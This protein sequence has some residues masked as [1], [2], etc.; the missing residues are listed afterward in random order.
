[1]WNLTQEKIDEICRKRDDKRQELRNLEATTKEELWEHDLAEFLKKLDTVEETERQEVKD[2]DG[3]AGGG[4]GAGK[5][6]KGGKGKGKG[7]A[8]VK[9]D[10]LPSQHATRLE[11]KVGD[12]L[13]AKVEQAAA[14]KVRAKAKKVEGVK[15]KGGK[16]DKDDFDAMAEDKQGV[17]QRI[18]SGDK[19]KQTKLNFKPATKKEN[20]FSDDDAGKLVLV[21][22]MSIISPPVQASPT[23][24][25]PRPRRGRRRQGPGPPPRS[26]CRTPTPRRSTSR[27]PRSV[28]TRPRWWRSTTPTRTKR[29]AAST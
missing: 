9:A 7:K 26:T 3:G 18:N 16:E 21:D 8:Q 12:D 10:T 27:P 22:R 11:P 28:A 4:G 17:R 2:G 19:T 1:M 25:T 5:S 13:K 23:S 6:A 24:P 20:P 14:A 29:L 15:P